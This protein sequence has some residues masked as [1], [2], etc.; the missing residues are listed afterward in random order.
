[1]SLLESIHLEHLPPDHTAHIAVY[2]SV[3][4]AAF[5][6]QQLLDGNSDFEYAF[7]DASVIISRTH[8]LAAVFRAVNDLL[9]GRLR[10]RNVH[11]EIVFCLS[12]SNNIAESFRRFGITP[13]TTTQLIIIKIS[14]PPTPHLSASTIQEHLASVIE[15]TQV[16]FTDEVLA[17]MTDWARVRKIYKVGG[18]SANGK[19]AVKNGD[20]G[21]A[22][23]AAQRREL[24]LQVLGAMALRG[25]GN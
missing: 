9:E 11:S 1:M 12:P 23:V 15:G 24:G 17:D 13:T 7:I 5:L 14:T 6:Q 10:S 22:A 3:T 8:V 18:G 20:G 16:P 2:Q 25:Y 21:A 4:N 19:Q